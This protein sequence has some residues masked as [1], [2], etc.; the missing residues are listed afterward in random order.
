MR[1]IADNFTRAEET[2][3]PCG[4]P[5]PG[6]LS[7]GP[8]VAPAAAAEVL[9][10]HFTGAGDGHDVWL[11]EDG[12][13]AETFD[14]LAL[15]WRRG[16][17]GAL[18]GEVSYRGAVVADVLM[19]GRGSTHTRRSLRDLGVPRRQAAVLAQYAGRPL[20]ATFSRGPA[21]SGD[22]ARRVHAVLLAS[23]T[24]WARLAA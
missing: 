17:D 5:G 1:L 3:E 7:A 8:G 22:L 6:R 10:V 20:L 15:S 12:A 13:E 14:G 16:P 2:D 21:L 24:R 9:C 23:L 19:L 18:H 11:A 4:G